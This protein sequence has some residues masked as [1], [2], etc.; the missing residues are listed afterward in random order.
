MVR[1]GRRETRPSGCTSVHPYLWVHH[2]AP[3]AGKETHATSQP[4]NQCFSK[5]F[6]IIFRL[7]PHQAQD[8]SSLH[9]A[10]RPGQPRL[11]PTSGHGSPGFPPTPGPLPAV[12]RARPEL[13]LAT[14]GLPAAPDARP[15]PCRSGGRGRPHLR[16]RARGPPPPPPPPGLTCKLGLDRQ[17]SCRGAG[18]AALHTGSLPPL[19]HAAA[20]AP[21]ARA[22]RARPAARPPPPAPQPAPGVP[23]RSAPPPAAVPRD[24]PATAAAR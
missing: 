13:G 10:P 17:P 14:T 9:T 12:G 5:A 8:G 7:S 21:A 16:V 11:P 4:H 6:P 3:P 20:S 1:K 2:T 19:R 22:G 23:L 24:P 15:S 18:P